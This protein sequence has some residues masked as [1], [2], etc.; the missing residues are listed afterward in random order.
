MKLMGEIEVDA[1]FGHR[2]TPQGRN[3]SES[4]SSSGRGVSFWYRLSRYGS[5]SRTARA[6]T[7][8]LGESIGKQ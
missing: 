5:L 2:S 8:N 6:S 1:S 7:C 4:L 3:A